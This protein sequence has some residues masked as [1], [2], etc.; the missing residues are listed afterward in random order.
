MHVSRCSYLSLLLVPPAVWSA[1]CALCGRCERV[2]AAPITPA[3]WTSR[4][5]VTFRYVEL[6]LYVAGNDEWLPEW[7]G[8]DCNDEVRLVACAGHDDV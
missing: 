1:A 6:T 5:G 7:V 3:D 2:V 4:G 8:V